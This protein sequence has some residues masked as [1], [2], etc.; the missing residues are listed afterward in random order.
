MTIPFLDIFKKAKARFGSGSAPATAERVR[1]APV[2]KPSSEKL[3]KTVMPN[4][5]KIS[6]P[7][8]DPF[9][10]A[11][12]SSPNSKLSPSA[13]RLPPSVAF[14]LQPKVER[15]ISLELS[16]LLS[17]FPAGY[18]KPAE[19]FNPAQT[20][21]LKACEIEKGMST[22]KPMVSLATIY[23]QMPDIFLRTVAPDDT[24][25]VG[26]PYEKVLQ[27]FRNVQI[28][29]D[30]EHEQDV[31]QVETPILKAT[32]EDTQR[33]G[34]PMSAIQASAHP[35]VKVEPAT[36]RAISTAEPEPAAKEAFAAAPKPS[37]IPLNLSPSGAPKAPSTTPSSAAPTRIPFK[38]PPNGTGGSDSE[39][40]PASSGPPVPTSTSKPAGPARVPFKISAP[41]DDLKPK[42]TLVP[43]VAGPEK[44]EEEEKAP[45][46]PAPDAKISLSLS[47][48]L[49]NMPAFQLK[50]TPEAI[51]ADERIEL[52]LASVQS[53]L[54][55]G[56][57]AVPMKA[58]RDASPEKYRDL[59]NAD[60]AESPVLLPLHEVLKNLPST[61]LKMR[62]DQ[63]QIDAIEGF[64]TPFSIKAA[65]DAKRLGPETAVEKKNEE[66]A[67]RAAVKVSEIKP[68]KPAAVKAPEVKAPEL[69]PAE[70]KAPE[71]KALELKTPELKRPELKTP[72]PVS[73]SPV[74]VQTK[75][76]SVLQ[77]AV[78]KKASVPVTPK[79]DTNTTAKEVVARAMALAG[80]TACSIT[81]EDGLSLAGNLPE[82]VQAG[83]LCAMAPSVLQRINRHTE[84]TK[85][86]PL[87][88]MTLHCRDSRMTFFM[89]GNVCLTALHG[90]GDLAPETQD[91]LAEMASEL[92][93]T[94][95]QPETAHVDH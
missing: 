17:E 74:P 49:H 57:I 93:R 31:P 8:S 32:I 80:V 40:V 20:I 89:K 10:A 79:I 83:G 11:S 5:T 13:G 47:A 73:L 70:L 22:G 43:G 61:F 19:S 64:E 55:S 71:A 72:P 45:L 54:A 1:P 58:L 29:D 36:A 30:Q 38:L 39:R 86:G 62:D 68:L 76:E 27:Q 82:D 52:P 75:A 15:A 95:T 25:R 6:S 7:G 41:C 3:S 60:E 90:S 16:D 26:L 67:A 87:L 9:K 53:Q 34:T 85:L 65:E 59:L 78:E 66:S 81:F 37:G 94:Y 84:E 23:E 12:N 44:E 24:T 28:R 46:T 91:K 35:P 14:A 56:R 4:T 48:V 18:L 2:E 69:K 63:E 51:G 50:G 42:L 21:L 33:F 88:S 92:S 77:P